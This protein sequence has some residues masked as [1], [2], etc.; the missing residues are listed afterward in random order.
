M[1]IKGFANNFNGMSVAI[2]QESTFA[3]FS[4]SARLLF[5]GA[6]FVDEGALLE[7]RNLS[8]ESGPRWI[9]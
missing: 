9:A 3:H 5:C 2:I 4:L 6:Y 8:G 7:T 1:Q